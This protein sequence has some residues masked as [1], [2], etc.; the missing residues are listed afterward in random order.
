LQDEL[1]LD[2]LQQ[3]TPVPPQKKQKSAR[4]VQ[5]LPGEDVQVPAFVQYGVSAASAPDASTDCWAAFTI[6]ADARSMSPFFPQPG[7]TQRVRNTIADGIQRMQRSF[8]FWAT[9]QIA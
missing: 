3:V 2:G 4:P 6:D 7:N 1:P 8:M 5:H 9:S